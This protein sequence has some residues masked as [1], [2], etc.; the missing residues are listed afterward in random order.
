L[1]LSLQINL[2]IDYAEELDEQEKKQVK[3]LVEEVTK[4]VQS[5]ATNWEKVKNLL[6]RSFDYG[7]KIAP[8]IVKLADTYYRAK[9][10]K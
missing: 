8:D 6:R 3:E 5:E 4:E 7:L 10:G 2:A 1:Q 9:G